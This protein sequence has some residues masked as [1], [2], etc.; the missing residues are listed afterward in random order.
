[1]LIDVPK[2]VQSAGI[3]IENLPD[4]GTP[5]PAP[6]PDAGRLRAAA[7][8]IRASRRTILYVGGGIIA[9]D[10]ADALL[11][12]AEKASIQIASTLLVLDA[13]PSR[14]PLNLGMLG[15]QAARRASRAHE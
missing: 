7:D 15:L 5:D 8:M 4:P 10:A 13:I 14:H 3:G 9:G 11:H 6:V 1:M 12:L 2:D